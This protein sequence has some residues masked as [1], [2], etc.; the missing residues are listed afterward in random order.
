MGSF[1]STAQAAAAAQLDLLGLA[2]GGD[3]RLLQ[4]G[5]GGLPGEGD[6]RVLGAEDALLVGECLDVLRL[7]AAVGGEVGERRRVLVRKEQERPA[8]RVDGDRR[9]GLALP[10]APVLGSVRTANQVIVTEND[11]VTEDLYAVG[12]RTIVE[13]VVHKLKLPEVVAIPVGRWRDVFDA[14][15]KPMSV[16]AQ[17]REIDAAAAEPMDERPRVEVLNGPHLDGGR[18]SVVSKAIRHGILPEPP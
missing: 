4:D 8:R 1:K 14:V 18:G 11:V 17:W 3:A 12:G 7:E 10:A 2:A 5:A 15:A 16:H 13:G 9:G 6:E